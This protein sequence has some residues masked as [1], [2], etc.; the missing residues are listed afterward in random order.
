MP[1]PSSKVD[2]SVSLVSQT[3][4]GLGTRLNVL[5]SFENV[6]CE[7]YL[8][9]KFI[10]IVLKSCKKFLSLF[11]EKQSIMP[12]VNDFIWKIQC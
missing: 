1:R 4:Q 11:F 3:L 2:K 6:T 9:V 7:L 8:S 5:E 12:P 10:S